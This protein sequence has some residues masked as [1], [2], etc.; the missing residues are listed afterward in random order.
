M[1]LG[2]DTDLLPIVGARVI[3]A[4]FEEELPPKE[5]SADSEDSDNEPLDD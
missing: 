4:E 1:L 3:K 5:D 2:I